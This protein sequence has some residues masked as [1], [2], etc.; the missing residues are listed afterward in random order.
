MKHAKA[1]LLGIVLFVLVHSAIAFVPD[2]V[3]NA[4]YLIMAWALLIGVLLVVY[5]TVVK[6]GW[7]VNLKPVSCPCCNR[8]MPKVRSPKSLREAFWGGG[9]CMNCGCEMDKWGRQTTTSH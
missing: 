7:G 2:K 1:I 8:T 3:M 5:G 9:T 4:I 6:N